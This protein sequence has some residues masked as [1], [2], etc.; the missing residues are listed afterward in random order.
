MF[1]LGLLEFLLG[2]FCHNPGTVWFDM[3]VSSPLQI[4]HYIHD[5]DH[6]FQFKLYWEAIKKYGEYHSNRLMLC[7]AMIIVVA[8]IIGI[9][10]SRKSSKPIAHKAFKMVILIL[11]PIAA[12]A[13][14]APRLAEKLLDTQDI[15]A[16]IVRQKIATPDD[17]VYY[18]G[19][20]IIISSIIFTYTSLKAWYYLTR[21]FYGAGLILSLL[22]LPAFLWGA[23][24][25]I[26]GSSTIVGLIVP[27]GLI[28]I[29]LTIVDAIAQLLD[30]VIGDETPLGRFMD[31]A[32]D[33]AMM[34]HIGREE[35]SREIRKEEEERKISV[36][37]NM[38]YSGHTDLLDSEDELK[39]ADAIKRGE[40]ISDKTRKWVTRDKFKDPD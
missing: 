13:F 9:C 14:V 32:A 18:Q 40:P 19:L 15:Y 36:L 39:L 28:L 21:R 1:L 17:G 23:W 33:A 5:E 37:D 35:I 20:G 25:I 12:A 16:Y 7:G 29:I 38:V 31:G 10:H 3:P 4:H 26:Q 24:I 6:W 8:L 2:F 30:K 34:V 11:V 22:L 27:I